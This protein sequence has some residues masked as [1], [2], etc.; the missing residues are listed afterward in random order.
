MLQ[1]QAEE[2]AFAIFDTIMDCLSFI[3]SC[4]AAV[5][6]AMAPGG[7]VVA[8]QSAAA[9]ADAGKRIG[10]DVKTLMN[11]PVKIN[12][13]KVLQ[14]TTPEGVRA[15]WNS[16]GKALVHASPIDFDGG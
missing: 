7:T 10:Q 1:K 5:G 9:A 6:S 2:K 15:A 16:V 4:V 8:A 13:V 14:D 3:G 11:A 12:I